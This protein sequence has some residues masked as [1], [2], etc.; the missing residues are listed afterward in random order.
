MFNF[1]FWFTPDFIWSVVL[2]E[3]I[4]FLSFPTEKTNIKIQKKA[5][6]QNSDYENVIIIPS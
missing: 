4:I 3:N 2:I 6:T 1:S 5:K